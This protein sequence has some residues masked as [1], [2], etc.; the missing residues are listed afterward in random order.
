[1]DRHQ[2]SAMVFFW[3]TNVT[4]EPS[5]IVFPPTLYF[6]SNLEGLSMITPARSYAF[7]DSFFFFGN[8]SPG[9]VLLSPSHR[10][11]VTRRR[12]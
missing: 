12:Q 5:D 6:D 1:M 7:E 2:M 10:S 3:I 4:D 8:S 11:T 9:P